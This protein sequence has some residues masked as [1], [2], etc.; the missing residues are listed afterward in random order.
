MGL[1]IISQT[2]AP[3]LE[4]EESEV[5]RWIETVCTAGME[6]FA[7]EG[8]LGITGLGLLRRQHLAPSIAEGV[9]GQIYLAPP[10]DTVQF[11]IRRIGLDDDFLYQAAQR[12]LGLSE[13]QASRFAYGVEKAIVKLLDT[14][15][16]A[17][18]GDLGV[19]T[20]TG[21]AKSLLAPAITTNA[22]G[23]NQE[24]TSATA[25][26]GG[27][28]TTFEPSD[29]LLGFLNSR[30]LHLEPVTLHDVNASGA[31]SQPKPSAKSPAP[32]AKSLPVSAPAKSP[33]TEIVATPAPEPITGSPPTPADYPF[34]VAEKRTQS[35]ATAATATQSASPTFQ[36]VLP[37]PIESDPLPSM[38]I[39]D[40]ESEGD[41]DERDEQRRRMLIT[42]VVS[43]TVL[44][45]IA[46]GFLLVHTF[47]PS[48]STT[49]KPSA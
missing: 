6:M 14:K 5:A 8:R 17:E 44:A 11:Q 46:L 27:V 47:S 19:F 15:G 42:L 32:V 9:G 13:E 29:A 37:P 35:S 25:P 1:K 21:Q 23:E 28:K 4:Q 31:A 41:D 45:V 3:L 12:E 48:V 30:Y 24:N 39:T 22:A 36:P 2:L 18:L 34:P 26:D 40:L 7:A 10:R 49:A 33:V 38:D 20:R 16:V 43:L